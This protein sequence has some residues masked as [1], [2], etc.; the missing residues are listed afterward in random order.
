MPNKEE[1]DLMYQDRVAIG[2]FAN[3]NY[4]SSSES[5]DFNAWGQFFDDGFQFGDFKLSTGRVRAVRA[6]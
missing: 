4:W 3:G 5:S 6:Y 1:L 2:G